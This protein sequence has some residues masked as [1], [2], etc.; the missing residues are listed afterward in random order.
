MKFIL[1]DAQQAPDLQFEE[2][3][4]AS[5]PIVPLPL[6][7]EKG[8]I[9]CVNE[10]VAKAQE[11]LWHGIVGQMEEA[12]DLNPDKPY[13]HIL[14]R[15]S[16]QC[17]SAD[18]PPHNI[19]DPPAE[20]DHETHEMIVAEGAKI[21]ETTVG[22]VGWVFVANLGIHCSDQIPQE[23][24]QVFDEFP[25]WTKPF[26]PEPT[27][28]QTEMVMKLMGSYKGRALLAQKMGQCMGIGTRPQ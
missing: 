4:I 3:E 13:M 5:N 15:T 14:V 22:E 19:Y 11:E 24:G 28:E 21:V 23:G 18:Q 6:L 10:A 1:Y 8:R 26:A 9:V 2:F 12:Q 25:W 20:W 16:P 7:K 17:L 27:A